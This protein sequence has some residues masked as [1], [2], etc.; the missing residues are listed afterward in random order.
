M[1]SKVVIPQFD[2]INYFDGEQL[3]AEDL[4]TAQ[5][6][7]ND[8]RW[9]HNRT[10]HGWGI[11]TGLGVTGKIGGR[12]VTIAPGMAIDVAG[13]EIILAKAVVQGI[14]SLTGGSPETL[15]YL[16][17]SYQPDS[18]Q[19]VVTKRPGVCHSGGAVR[20]ANDPLVQWQLPTTVLQGD[21]II[22]AGVWIKSCAISRAI[23]TAPRRPV[24]PANGPSVASGQVSAASIQWLPF[25][26]GSAVAGFTA[27]VD[28]SAL[29]FQS[30]PQYLAQI[31][32]D[33]YL[34]TSPGPLLAVPQVSVTNA[35]PTGF[36]L[37][38]LLPQA[39]AGV[40]V[41]PPAI[42]D[43]QTGPQIFTS[44]G[45][46]IAFNAAMSSTLGFLA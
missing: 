21:Q 26:A 4:N 44:L 41:N 10:L 22:L 7:D 31:T 36:T 46:Q 14:P 17:A 19:A 38:A 35:S 45:W 5:L 20:L 24:V 29:Q 34:P 6:I 3:T 37:Q 8:L 33:N 18:V 30:T 1:S 15:F 42:L 16:T 43:P 40:P 13:R 25:Q 27:A 11:A 2:R 23:S 9:L 32:G 12:S 28:T 39:T